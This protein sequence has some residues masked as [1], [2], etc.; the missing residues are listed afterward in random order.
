MEV[1]FL[2]AFVCLSEPKAVTSSGIFGGIY[3][4]AS[5]FSRSALG[6][7]SELRLCNFMTSRLPGKTVFLSSFDVGFPSTSGDLVLSLSWFC[8][9]QR[10]SRDPLS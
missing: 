5:L 3:L 10:V 8:S 1:C 6:T 4:E 7:S 9:G 2:G